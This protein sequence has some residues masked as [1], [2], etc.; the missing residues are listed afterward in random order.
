MLTYLAKDGPY[1]ATTV[2]TIKGA[3]AE[4]VFTEAPNNLSTDADCQKYK[5]NVKQP[6]K[7][8]QIS[9]M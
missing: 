2:R 9:R 3:C 7:D 5:N 4:R 1:K 6:I 8:A